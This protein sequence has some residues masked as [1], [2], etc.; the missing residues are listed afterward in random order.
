MAVIG[1]LNKKGRD[2]G[3]LNQLLE[4]VISEKQ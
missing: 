4:D 3:P 2:S 1:I